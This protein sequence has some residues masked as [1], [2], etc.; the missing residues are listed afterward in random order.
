MKLSKRP[1]SHPLFSV[2]AKD[3]R[4]PLQL[5]NLLADIIQFFHASEFPW[6]HRTWTVLLESKQ[7]H[8]S[9]QIPCHTQPHEPIHWT[10]STFHSS[11]GQ[12]SCIPI[13]QMHN[14]SPWHVVWDIA[15]SYKYPAGEPS[16]RKPKCQAA[17]IAKK[18]RRRKRS[19][20]WM[21][22]V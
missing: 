15:K 18:K 1:L 14:S 11:T 13:L 17:E 9:S 20:T 7:S 12:V 16:G 8:W 22:T 6:S 2:M 5:C 19:P 21:Q 3:I 10:F 4:L